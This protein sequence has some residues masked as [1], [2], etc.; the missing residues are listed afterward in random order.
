MINFNTTCIKHFIYAI[1]LMGMSLTA[2]SQGVGVNTTSPE[3]TL[4][5]KG[6]TCVD[7]FMVEYRDSAKL[8]TFQNGGTSVGSDTIP[9]KDGLYVPKLYLSPTPKPLGLYCHS[10][11]RAAR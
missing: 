7:P 1:F 4:H 5:V 10:H 2:R 6:S 9:P 8:K 11:I 3:A